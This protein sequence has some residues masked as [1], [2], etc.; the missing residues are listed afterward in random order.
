[1]KSFTFYFL[2]TLLFPTICFSQDSEPRP[3]G[4][5]SNDFV[6]KESPT[7]EQD[8]DQAI[9]TNDPVTELESSPNEDLQLEQEQDS[10]RDFAPEDSINSIKKPN[11]KA[12]G[13]KQ[14]LSIINQLKD[15]LKKDEAKDLSISL[16]VSALP[17]NHLAPYANQLAKLKR[18]HN[19]DVK[20]LYVVFE[21]LN[22]TTI[23]QSGLLYEP[24]KSALK[25]L[26]KYGVEIN[27]VS[28][29]P[30]HIVAKNSPLWVV[31][32]SGKD[33]ILEG[34]RNPGLF[35]DRTG[36]FDPSRIDRR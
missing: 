14:R 8:T 12:D 32:V 19:I 1:M 23:Q 7:L 21:T 34:Y 28:K 9:F 35:I 4:F 31:S 26:H 6:T 16:F 5:F 30:K 22:A 36:S 20:A 3:D 2:A 29:L 17:A 11:N 18:Q 10:S 13:F 33:H 25:E 15:S 24:A 27:A